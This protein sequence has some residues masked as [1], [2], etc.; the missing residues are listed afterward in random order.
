[1]GVFAR[2]TRQFVTCSFTRSPDALRSNTLF[3][4]GRHVLIC[5]VLDD[6]QAHGFYQG[7]QSIHL[8]VNYA[9]PD[10]HAP[11]L[12]RNRLRRNPSLPA[13]HVSADSLRS[14]SPQVS[15]LP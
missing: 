9:T 8:R 4:V 10:S 1:M 14:V 5:S 2:S 12:V 15:Q 6:A 13:H 11:Q 3:R 7:V